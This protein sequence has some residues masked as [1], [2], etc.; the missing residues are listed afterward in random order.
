M[1]QFAVLGIGSFGHYL[2]IHLFEKGHEVLA[3]D[4]QPDLI[5]GIK[6]KVSHA[7]VA[8]VTDITALESFGLKEMDAVIL[9]I[10]DSSLS[11]SILAALNL[12]DLGVTRL[13]AKAINE[14]QARILRKI[15]VDEIFFPEKD[16]ALLM[17][18]RLHNPNILDYLPFA[19][20]YS[21]SQLSPP[22]S[23]IGKQLRELNLINRYGVQIVAIKETASERLHMI[24]T[25]EYRL[26]KRE[27]MI[28]LGPNDSLDK[29]RNDES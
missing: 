25:G 9:C 23:F 18:D 28:I 4:N 2:A 14:S 16:Q 7:V 8:D 3:L 21:I 12:K 26:K 24:P 6:D 10:G 13:L 11:N 1:G 19:P 27:V 5:Q 17:G 15:G 22:K 29:L 20:G